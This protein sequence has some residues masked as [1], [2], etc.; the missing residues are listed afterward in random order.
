MKI[1]IMTL[2]LIGIL[3]GCYIAVAEDGKEAE[4]ITIFQKYLSIGDYI[5]V[6]KEITITTV[7]N[8]LKNADGEIVKT[9][10][11]PAYAYNFR[12]KLTP[13]DDPSKS[14][15]LWQKETKR[16]KSS[17]H[18]PFGE[19][20]IHDIMIENNIGYILATEE[21]FVVLEQFSLS[22]KQIPDKAKI[23][24]FRESEALGKVVINGRIFESNKVIYCFL[25]IAHNNLIELWKVENDK[26][27]KVWQSDEIINK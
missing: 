27:T 3:G 20:K 26:G 8:I 11:E 9:T 14:K 6:E 4:K 1:R 10:D 23:D 19:I 5:I 17:L 15:I 24:I 13:K 12:L 21:G 22:D 2:V 7:K 25:Q 18:L 16:P